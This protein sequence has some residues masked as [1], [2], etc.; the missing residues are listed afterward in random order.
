[1]VG[2]TPTSTVSVAKV[3]SAFVLEADRLIAEGGQHFEAVGRVRLRAS[4][5]LLEA[6]RVAVDSARSV[7]TA[8]ELRFT[9]CE[10]GSDASP[11]WAIG[12]QKARIDPNRGASLTW[13]VLYIEGVPVFALP[14]GYWP[15]GSRRSGLLIPAVKSHPAFGLS[16]EQPVYVVLGPSWDA[17]MTPAL[18][19]ARGPSMNLELRNHLQPDIY[20]RFEARVGFDQGVRD[21]TGWRWGSE[22]RARYRVRGRQLIGTATTSESARSAQWRLEIDAVGD[23]AGN[24]FEIDIIDRQAEWAR[25]RLTYRDA[26]GP[27]RV[28]ASL[29][30]QQDLR[31]QTYPDRELREVVLLTN[32]RARAVRQRLAELRLDLVP[33]VVAAGGLGAFTWAAW[34]GARASVQLF[35]AQDPATPRFFRAD[36]RPA[37]GLDAGLPLGTTLSAEVDLRGTTWLGDGIDTVSRW[38]PRIEAR[39]RQSWTRQRARWRH[40]IRPEIGAVY[41]PAI[42][43]RQESP[44][45]NLDELDA[46]RRAA[47]L[48]LRLASELTS[49]HS[50]LS[51]EAWTGR[52]VRPPGTRQAGLGWTP[53]VV[54]ASTRTT[55]GRWSGQVD[56]LATG[57]WSGRLEALDARVA[58]AAPRW[59][60]GASLGLLGPR[61][62]GAWFVA[63]EEILP[64]GTLGGQRARYGGEPDGVPWRRQTTV[65]LWSSLLPWRFLE[66]TGR[67]VLSLAESEALLADQYPDGSRSLVRNAAL[68]TAY[69]STCGCWSVAVD[70]AFGRDLSG[71]SVGVQLTLGRINPLASRLGVEGPGDWDSEAGKRAQARNGTPTCW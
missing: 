57:T 35:G 56:M 44:F 18:R 68:R 43:G 26:Q 48:Y 66:V 34:S 21:G 54:Q 13:P 2:A 23:A 69:V 62:P 42:G 61:P 33:Q 52:D 8:S 9:P 50:R 60:A 27:V 12:A 59:S 15:L 38:A 25:T 65:A 3:D 30:W 17:T 49:S 19:T 47:Q 70:S 29:Q 41:I 1:M 4:T 40:E 51:L 11:S 46:L 7:V 28:A 37:V 58:V 14:W 39:L 16:I 32:A 67:V 53:W 20:G 6:D 64:S 24:E 31:P 45:P 55:Q 22:R 10:C 63:A 5:F 71:F 36:L